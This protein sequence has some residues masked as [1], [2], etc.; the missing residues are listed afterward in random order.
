MINHSNDLKD[1]Q[2]EFVVPEVGN[3]PLPTIDSAEKKDY[4]ISEISSTTE[5][6]KAASSSVDW[7]GLESLLEFSKNQAKESSYYGI[8]SVRNDDK[9]FYEYHF[10]E[11]EFSRQAVIESNGKTELFIL[12]TDT[13]EHGVTRAATAII[14]SGIHAKNEILSWLLP[15]HTQPA[16]LSMEETKLKGCSWEET[17]PGGWVIFPDGSKTYFPPIKEWICENNYGDDVEEHYEWPS[18]GGGSTCVDPNGCNGGSETPDPC[19]GTGSSE[20]CDPNRPCP[21]DPIKNPEIAPTSGQDVAG[22]RYGAHRN[23]SVGWHRGLDIKAPLNSNLY[24]MHEGLVWSSSPPDSDTWGKYVIIRTIVNGDAFYMV[25]AH[26]NQVRVLEG[27]TISQGEMIGRSGDSGNAEG[28]VPHVHL[29]VRTAVPGKV[30]NDWDTHNPET[31][32]GTKFDSSGNP[33]ASS[34]CGY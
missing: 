22:G 23:N 25:Y 33:V 6:H 20:I 3:T 7:K 13:D 12:A 10:I 32:L 24:S 27:S 29:E 28:S 9:E 14:P 26:L 19:A 31:Y 21:G 17:V 2:G 4:G 15:K 34:S 1:L 18:G 11:L 5:R 30:F 8:F 16:A